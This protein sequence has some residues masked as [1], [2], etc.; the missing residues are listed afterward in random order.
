MDD[1]IVF[2]TGVSKGL[3]RVPAVGGEPEVLTT[4]DSERGEIAHYWPHVMPDGKAVLFTV[5][6]GSDGG[7]RSPGPLRARGQGARVAEPH[8]HW[9]Y[10]RPGAVRRDTGARP[11]VR[12]RIDARGPDRAGTDSARRY[13]EGV[14]Y[15][16]VNGQLAIDEGHR[17][18]AHARRRGGEAH[19]NA[20]R[21]QAMSPWLSLILTGIVVFALHLGGTWALVRMAGSDKKKP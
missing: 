4:V 2:A 16:L 3:L 14:K 9:P 7:R 20:R 8:Q 17:W 5:F 21:R 19:L 11:G 15:A 1:R 12:R 6:F 10:L 18:T 13:S